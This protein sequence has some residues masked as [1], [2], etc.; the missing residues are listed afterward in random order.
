MV[1]R[2][3]ELLLSSK[4]SVKPT[5]M[6]KNPSMVAMIVSKMKPIARIDVA[7]MILSSIEILH[8]KGAERLGA[9]AREVHFPAGA[10][11]RAYVI[12]WWEYIRTILL[13]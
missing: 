7:S 8:K 4:L 2:V 3:L 10:I 11:S 5:I 12:K 6:K 9:R 1:I 13:I